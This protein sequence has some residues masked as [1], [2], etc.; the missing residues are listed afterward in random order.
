MA[1][2]CQYGAQ[3]L[4]YFRALEAERIALVAPDV[5]YYQ[6]VRGAHVGRP[7]VEP[8]VAALWGGVGS[9]GALES[10]AAAWIFRPDVAGGAAPVAFPAVVEFQ[11]VDGR[12][13]AVREEG[14]TVEY[15]A[16]VVVAWDLWA[17]AI[18]GTA[19]AG[20]TPKEGDVL[21]GA[22]RWWDIVAAN[23]GGVVAALSAGT[24]WKLALKRRG[25]FVPERKI[26]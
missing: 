18:V 22:G 12:Q 11:E 7:N 23:A 2:R 4:A 1:R 10:D 20:A 17:C 13:V 3:D 5:E 19:L 14:M 26:P 6:V 16:T 21:Y 24:G 8:T 25:G 9:A 15:D